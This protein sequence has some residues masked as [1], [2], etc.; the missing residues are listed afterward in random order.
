MPLLSLTRFIAALISALI[1]AAAGYLLWTW[2]Q[3]EWARD[4]AGHL[5]TVREAWRLWTGAGLLAW[6]FL[7][8]LLLPLLLAK[9]GGQSP[10]VSHGEG[11]TV[12]GA[13]G[14]TLYVERH[15]RSGAPLVVFTHGWG[16]DLTFWSLARRDMADRFR[17]VLW[18]L[19]GLGRSKPPAG[20]KI[21]LSGFAADLRGL[22]ETLDRPAVL[23]GH[24]IGG[25]IIQTLVR[26][27][28]GS[29][30][31]VAGIVL[32]NTT[33]T[34]P[35]KTMIFSSVL[36]VLEKPLLRPAMHLTIW[37]KPLV[38][39]SKWQSYLSGSMHAGM[40]LGF[41]KFAT[42]G[43][44]EHVA[45]L[46]AQASPA[47][48]A[49]GNLAMFD[50]DATG[51]LAGL[52]KPVLVLGGDL[53]IVT[54]LRA[55]ETLAGESSAAQLEVIRGVNHMGPLERAD[56]YNEAIARF[57]LAVQPSATQDLSKADAGRRASEGSVDRGELPNE[58]REDPPLLH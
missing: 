25:M 55:S 38:W 51:V 45:R 47:I 37:L 43:Q 36:P 22:L 5:V 46:A 7:G 16:M 48:E 30:D 49:K 2:Y 9:G 57:A 19:P 23:V 3:G 14:S 21:T 40:R 1:L 53:D 13:S 10:S 18:D 52:R 20:G 44:L 34:N 58:A 29:L 41:G 11:Q 33:Y 39:L 6:S 35:L 8:R 27:H 12:T 24:S 31:R 50:W 26:D 54:K 56:L 32:L 42:R 15:G 28:P 17:L 4:A